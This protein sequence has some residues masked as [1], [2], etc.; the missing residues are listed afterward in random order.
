LRSRNPVAAARTRRGR[1]RALFAEHVILVEGDDDAA[2][3]E[4]VGS[5]VNQLAVNGI[6]VAPVNG[7]QNL[8]I[9]FAILRLLEIPVLVV[10]DNDQGLRARMEAQG[11]E[12]TSI[13]TA[14][15]K[16]VEENRA[17][18]RFVGAA[19]DDYPVGAVAGL[20]AFVPDTLETLLAS[21]LPGWDLTRQRVID[22]GGGVLKERT[23]RHTPSPHA[24]ATTNLATN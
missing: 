20:I 24:N 14:V 2:I 16:N 17:F 5:R 8:L 10:V 12:Q 23:Q 13:D 1:P 4:G 22:E 6:C 19:E 21:D 9:P 3:L 7:K 15:G 18:C 11:R